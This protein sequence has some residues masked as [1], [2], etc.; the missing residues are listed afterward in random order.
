MFGK[1]L[2]LFRLFG[3]EVKV[4]LSW[5]V[6]TVLVAWSLAEGLFPAQVKDYR[7]RRIGGWA[8]PEPSAFSLRSSSM[9]CGTHLSPGNSA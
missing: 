9:N 3:F 2:K 8:L 5:L 4:D 7:P 1:S 6:I